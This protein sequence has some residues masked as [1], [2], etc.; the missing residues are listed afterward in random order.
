MDWVIDR[1]DPHART[2]R[3]NG[4]GAFDM[5]RVEESIAVLKDGLELPHAPTPQ[6]LLNLD[7]MP[8]QTER[9]IG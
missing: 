8:P 4:L 9:N 1:T 7:F 6:T 3:K 2:C 5:K